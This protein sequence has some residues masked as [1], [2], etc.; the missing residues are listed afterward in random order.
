[1]IFVIAVAMENFR[2]F[3]RRGVA[4]IAAMKIDRFRLK[5]RAQAAGFADQKQAPS[6][7]GTCS[8]IAPRQAV[9]R[10]VFGSLTD[11]EN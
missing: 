8:Q 1:L 11:P 6:A 7:E 10:I 9:R 3:F 5:N 4:S 2:E